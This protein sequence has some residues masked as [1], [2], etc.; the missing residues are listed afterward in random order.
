VSRNCVG[1]FRAGTDWLGQEPTGRHCVSPGS[2]VSSSEADT[3]V[4]R[5]F[6]YRR[7][8]PLCVKHN[9]AQFDASFVT[10]TYS[11]H[12]IVLLAKLTNNVLFRAKP[13]ESSRSFLCLRAVV[14]VSVFHIPRFPTTRGLRPTAAQMETAAIQ[15]ALDQAKQSQIELQQTQQ[16]LA[17]LQL[18]QQQHAQTL[19]QTQQAQQQLGQ[20]LAHMQQSLN[21]VLQGQQ[22]DSQMLVQVLQLL[23]QLG[24]AGPPQT[25]AIQASGQQEG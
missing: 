10:Y 23:G 15:Q 11:R 14:D 8:R 18:T 17:Q 19:A 13:Y 16:T 3:L 9:W 4:S 22:Q 12:L 24:Q 6:H 21:Q 20:T 2:T 7:L 25:G 5:H 1:T